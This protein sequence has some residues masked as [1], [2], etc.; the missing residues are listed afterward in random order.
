MC[1]Q[2]NGVITDWKL[3][4]EQP[5][6]DNRLLQ[7]AVLRLETAYGVVDSVCTDR[8][9]ASKQNETFLKDHKIYDAM[10]PRSP[11]QL[12]ERLKEER[13]VK[14]QTRRGQTEARIGIFKNSF[15][16][17]PLRS[18]GFLHKELTVSWCVL[19]HNLWVIARMA[20]ADERSALEK[21]A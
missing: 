1:E 10:C 17:R 3:S 20:I 16:G 14:L 21:V 19:T 12:Q 6:S 5:P 4:Q 11:R 13:F 18:K 2:A 9:F 8:G 15:L 7:E